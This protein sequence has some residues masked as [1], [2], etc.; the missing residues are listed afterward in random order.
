[1]LWVLGGMSEATGHPQPFSCVNPDL[2]AQD[3]YRMDVYCLHMAPWLVTFLPRVIRCLWGGLCLPTRWSTGEHPGAQRGQ[4]TL[5]HWEEGLEQCPL[6]GTLPFDFGPLLPSCVVQILVLQDHNYG[7]G[8]GESCHLFISS[9]V[10]P[11]ALHHHSS[12][13]STGQWD[14]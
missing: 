12:N 1:M 6:P 8:G 2:L 14:F 10:T 4:R 7:G 11:L 3:V 5:E 13:S 9:A